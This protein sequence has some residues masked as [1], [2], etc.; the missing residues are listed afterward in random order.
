M[1]LLA[2]FVA[3]GDLISPV[4]YHLLHLGDACLN[5]VQVRKWIMMQMMGNTHNSGITL[6]LLLLMGF[7]GFRS[8]AALEVMNGEDQEFFVGSMAKLAEKAASTIVQS[9]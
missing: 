4:L 6:G 9:M 7:L 1:T 5:W 2:S 8:C 3:A